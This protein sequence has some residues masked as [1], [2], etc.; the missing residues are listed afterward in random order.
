MP[1]YHVRISRSYEELKGFFEN[2][3]CTHMVVYEHDAD[4]EVSRTHCH[5]WIKGCANSDTL[6]NHIRKLIGPVSKTDWYF[7]EKN[8]KYV[9]WTDDVMTYLSKGVL[10]V[11]YVIGFTEAEIE[12]KKNKWIKIETKPKLFNED[13]KLIIEKEIKE[14]KKKTKRELIELMKAR[15]VE[16]M[17]VDEV[18]KLIRKVLVQNDEVIGMYKVMDYYDSLIMYANKQKFIDMVTQKINSRLRV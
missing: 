12:E 4:E 11:K 18:V 14:K 16:T 13:G 6:K 17:D 1:N 2:E 8:K 5:A 15:Y 9:E 7:T 3:K 10:E